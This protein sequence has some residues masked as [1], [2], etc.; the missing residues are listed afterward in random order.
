MTYQS[1]L[2]MTKATH[3]ELQGHLFPGDGLE[4]AAILLCRYTGKQQQ[5]LCVRDV[6]LVPLAQCVLRTPDRLVWPGEW[7]ER[8]I[9]AAETCGDTIILMHSH[10]AGTY[11]F[12]QIDD[13]SDCLT[14]RALS[15]AFDGPNIRHGTAI[16]TPDGA[17][18]ARL[19]DSPLNKSGL[20]R[21]VVVGED[22]KEVT[23]EGA[24]YILPFS[25]DMRHRLAQQTA[26]IVGVSGTGSVVAELLFRLGFGHVILIEFDNMETKNLNRILN[27]TLEDAKRGASKL[28]VAARAAQAHRS[29]VTIETCDQPIG[30]KAALELASQSDVIFCCVDSVEGRHH[31]DI[32]SQACLIPIVDIGV[33][34][35]TRSASDGTARIADVC[36]RID[37]VT[38]GLSSLLD[39]GVVTPEALHRE[40]LEKVDPEA[41]AELLD[42]GYIKG[43][44]S[45]APSVISLNMR[46]ASAGVN[47]WLARNFQFRE[48]ENSL[49]ARTFF[50]LSGCEEEFYSELSFPNSP[51]PHLASGMDAVMRQLGIKA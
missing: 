47:E 28:S 51:K 18:L 48:E 9:D 46:A 12:S 31:C 35:P 8:A 22:V 21:P 4:A 39:R 32:L 24:Q 7:I 36:G 45:E 38:P 2:V 42:D 6:L 19:Y 34:I 49:Y 43:V 40:Y 5:R 25:D 16:M 13:D 41:L 11:A 23:P 3:L 20:L 14:I 50:T 15:E 33:T 26:C 29:E 44:H 27:S 1:K 17:I 30:S 37:Y 10:P